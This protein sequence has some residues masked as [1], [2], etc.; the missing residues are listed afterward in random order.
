MG[1]EALGEFVGEWDLEVGLPGVDGLRGR[2][3]FEVLGEAMVQR[4]FVPVPE[5]PDSLS[6]IVADRDGGYV[7]HYF[8]SR[9]VARLYEMTFDGTTWI[10]ERNKADFSPLD[11]YQRY[12]GVFSDDRD[13]IDGEW[14]TSDDGV[15]WRRDFALGYRRARTA[16]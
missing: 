1:I 7:Q 9:G 11:F 8:D 12:V 13:S 6:V 3:V 5:A 4:I 14:Q 10:L 16:T 15:E 2:V